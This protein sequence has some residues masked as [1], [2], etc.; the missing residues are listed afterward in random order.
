MSQTKLLAIHRGNVRYLKSVVLFLVV[1]ITACTTNLNTQKWAKDVSSHEYI[2]KQKSVLVDKNCTFFDKLSPTYGIQTANNYNKN[3]IWTRA[4]CN[5][6][7]VSNVDVGT[8]I[9]ITDISVRTDASGRCWNVLAKLE[10]GLEVFIPSC[11]FFHT[12]L[13]V[14]PQQ[15]TENN[16]EFKFNKAYLAIE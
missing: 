11:K 4:G 8:K 7:I 9:I 13:W 12:N 10:N 5:P 2:I 6:Q 1:F 16:L 15:P 14:T 3:G